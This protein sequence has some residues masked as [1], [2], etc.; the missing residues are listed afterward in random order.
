MYLTRKYH[1]V[2]T[3]KAIAY[4]NWN[5]VLSMCLTVLIS[6]FVW[7]CMFYVQPTCLRTAIWFILAFFETR[8]GFFGEP[9]CVSQIYNGGRKLLV[10]ILLL[11]WHMQSKDIEANTSLKQHAFMRAN[12]IALDRRVDGGSSISLK[13][14]DTFRLL[15]LVCMTALVSVCVTGLSVEMVLHTECNSG[16]Y[17]HSKMLNSHPNQ[18]PLT[19]SLW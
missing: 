8:S 11:L 7:L 5:C 17:C 15:I 14:L 18:L 12:F 9:D 2:F 19:S 3:R 4:K 10:P 6:I 1:S 16:M 13:L